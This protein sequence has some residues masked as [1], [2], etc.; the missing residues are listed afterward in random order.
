MKQFCSKENMLQ[1][2]LCIYIY[3]CIKCFCYHF[4]L[5]II[6]DILDTCLLMH[7]MT[8]A[9]I[10]SIRPV[11]W[12]CKPFMQNGLRYSNIWTNLFPIK[13]TLLALYRMLKAKT[14]TR[15]SVLL[16]LSLRFKKKQS[17]FF[18]GFQ[19]KI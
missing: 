14:L 9:V 18:W 4:R 1:F 17:T 12:I 7:K 10:C 19:L 13:C 11:R 16:H 15:C 3:T 8:N 5:I 6:L 2:W